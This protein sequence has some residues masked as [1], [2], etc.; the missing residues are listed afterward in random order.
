MEL[1]LYDL[2]DKERKE[3]GI[4]AL[5]ENL[6]EA[7]KVTENSPLVKEILGEHS[8]ERFIALKKAEWDEFR[9][10]VTDWEIKKYLSVL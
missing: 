10:Q 4:E 8:F 2:T 7:I 9:L 5:P 6:G 3:K 1:N